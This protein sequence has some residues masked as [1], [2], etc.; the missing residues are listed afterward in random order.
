MLTFTGFCRSSIGDIM[1]VLFDETRDLIQEH[2]RSRSMAERLRAHALDRGMV[3][4]LR[5]GIS[6]IF[7]G[8][9]DLLQVRNA[10]IG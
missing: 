4:L 8:L 7:E 6:K 1:F 9:C 5:D 3:T 2:G 10:C